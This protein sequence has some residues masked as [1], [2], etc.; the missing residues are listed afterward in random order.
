VDYRLASCAI[1]WLKVL[2][3]LLLRGVL[4]AETFQRM[5]KINVLAIYRDSVFICNHGTLIS[6]STISAKV[7]FW[8]KCLE[9]HVVE[10]LLAHP[11]L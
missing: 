5:S 9:L 2:A 1:V 6:A 7:P 4:E 8:V 10:V 3:I 11:V